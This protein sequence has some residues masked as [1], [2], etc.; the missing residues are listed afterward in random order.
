M[1]MWAYCT[2]VDDVLPLLA[3]VPLQTLVL[4]AHL[5]LLLVRLR[6]RPL[7][8][9]IDVLAVSTSTIVAALF[10]LVCLAG[11]TQTLVPRQSC[12]R[13]VVGTVDGS[14]E[15]GCWRER[16]DEIRVEGDSVRLDLIEQAFDLALAP[17]FLV[18][19][20]VCFGAVEVG[21]A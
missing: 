7:L 8:M 19:E 14:A 12:V 2:R 20:G 11:G 9:A 17:G 1:T 4:P 15:R 16:T 10:C 3:E 6:K 21:L 13:D 18:L 5:L